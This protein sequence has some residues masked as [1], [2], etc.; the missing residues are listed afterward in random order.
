MRNKALLAALSVFILFS[1]ASAQDVEPGDVIRVKT[2]LVNSPVLVIGRDGKFVPNLR[3]EDFEVFENGVKQEIAYFAPV[4]NPF[5]VAILIDTSRSALFEL[6]DIQEAAIA[7]VDKM[8]PNDRALVVSF[9]NEA[10]RARGTDQRSRSAAP[11]DSQCSNLA[12]T[13]ACTTRSTSCS[14]NNSRAFEG[15]NGVDSVYRW[16]R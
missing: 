11:R 2:T 3:R 16:R 12:A 13:H 1:I 5:T 8:R 4:D 7:F 10:T 15:Q 9:S 14:A 6:Q